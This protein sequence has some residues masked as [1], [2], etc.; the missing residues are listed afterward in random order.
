M[1]LKRQPD[2]LCPKCGKYSKCMMFAGQS[3]CPVPNK[4]ICGTCAIKAFEK[5]HTKPRRRK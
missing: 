1:E 2:H 5:A 4:V 3:A